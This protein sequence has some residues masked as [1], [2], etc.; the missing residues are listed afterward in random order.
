MNNY[1]IHLEIR[2]PKKQAIDAKLEAM[3]CYLM[4]L[5]TKEQRNE[6]QG[7][8]GNRLGLGFGEAM[9]HWMGRGDAGQ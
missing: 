8:T 1:N 2:N 7:T 9:R 3:A 5:R 6:S 4:N